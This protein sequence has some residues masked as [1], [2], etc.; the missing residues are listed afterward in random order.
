MARVSDDHADET[1]CGEHLLPR[2]APA[3]STCAPGPRLISP[4]EVSQH[5]GSDGTSFWGVVDGFVVDASE[6]VDTHPGGLKKLLSVDSAGAGANGKP[7]GFSFS[8]GRNAH[9]PDT[10][11]RFHDGVKRF[12]SG[13][14]DGQVLPP[15]E[16]SFPPYGKLT[17]LGRLAQA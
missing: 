15:A 4:D 14:G 7:F 1:L 17:I 12:L 9:F 13:Q 6:F 2:P 5:S 3:G 10:G 11:K 16:V 8:R